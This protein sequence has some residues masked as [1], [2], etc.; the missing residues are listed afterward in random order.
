M[1]KFESKKIIVHER[2]RMINVN[3][4]SVRTPLEHIVN[5]QERLDF[6]LK[7]LQIL[8]IENFEIDKVTKKKKGASYK[9]VPDRPAKKTITPKKEKKKPETTLER[10]T[11]E[12]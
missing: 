10:L 2:N 3:G 11:D 5:S 9:H 4:R 12:I 1:A 6:F 7:Q 8:N